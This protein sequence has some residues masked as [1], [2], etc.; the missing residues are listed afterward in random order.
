MLG[1]VRPVDRVCYSGTNVSLTG[2]RRYQPLIGVF[3]IVVGVLFLS[4]AV[5]A[6]LMELESGRDAGKAVMVSVVMIACGVYVLRQAIVARRAM[7]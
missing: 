4:A 7:R 1:G 3:L 6:L 5:A 2:G